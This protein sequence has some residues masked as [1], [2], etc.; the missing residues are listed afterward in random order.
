MAE[1]PF[2]PLHIQKNV[3]A[4]RAGLSFVARAGELTFVAD[5]RPIK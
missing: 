5:L 3:W 4:T 1:I 2:I